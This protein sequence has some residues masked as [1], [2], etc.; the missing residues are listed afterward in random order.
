[1]NWFEA[2]QLAIRLIGAITPIIGALGASGHETVDPTHLSE[3]DKAHIALLHAAI[4]T[5]ASAKASNQTG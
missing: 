1:M 2:L 4:N 5:P 3:Q